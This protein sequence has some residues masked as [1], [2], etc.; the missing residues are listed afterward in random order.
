M[1]KYFI[2]TILS[3]VINMT[4]FAQKDCACCTEY[5]NQFDFWLGEWVVHDTLGNEVGKNKI[6]KLEQNC[7][8]SEQWTGAKGGS[9]RSYNYYNQTD[10]TWN[11]L[12][13]DSYGSNLE[14]KG[15]L[16]NGAMILK[17][18]IL[19]SKAGKMYY[20]QISWIPNPDGTVTQLWEIISEKDV[21]LK[22][23]FRGIYSRKK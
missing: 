1:S 14:L 5:N 21:I 10:S 13:I 8:L 19:E 7:L 22:T 3:L 23:A 6:Q 16:H 11:Q 17:S 2:V 20:N 9:G 12:W 15:N 18:A 4:I